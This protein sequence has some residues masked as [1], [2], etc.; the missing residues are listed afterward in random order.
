MYFSNKVDSFLSGSNS[1]YVDQMY[2]SWKRDPSR[3]GGNYWI[4]FN[5]LNDLLYTQCALLM[6]E[7]F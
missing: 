5:I 2:S 4:G 7:L 1:V 6:G 3:F